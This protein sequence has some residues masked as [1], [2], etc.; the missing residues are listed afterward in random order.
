[1][2]SSVVSK[3]KDL[4]V[5]LFLLQSAQVLLPSSFSRVLIVCWFCAARSAAGFGTLLDIS[6]LQ[7]NELVLNLGA[8]KLPRL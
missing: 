5:R 3:D 6:M 2:L 4:F 7:S 1:M 8:S